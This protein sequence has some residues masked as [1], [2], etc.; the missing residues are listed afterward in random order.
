MFGHRY[1]GARYFGPRYFGDGGDEA[2]VP[3]PVVAET[4]SGGF[5]EVPHVPR[6]RSVRE[7]RERLGIIPRQVKQIAQAV[8]RASVVAD[9]TD[10]QAQRQLEQRLAQ[11]A[12]EAKARYVQFMKQE[13]DRILSRDIERAIRIRQRQYE[14]DEDDREAEMLLM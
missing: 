7:E 2:P 4:Y 1:F 3:P 10:D 8:A 14:L 12:I 13:R 11:K 9:K 6:R 5:Y